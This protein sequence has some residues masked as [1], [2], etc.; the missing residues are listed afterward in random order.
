MNRLLLAVLLSGSV[1]VA[2]AADAP[3]A[4]KPAKGEAKDEVRAER[5]AFRAALA[6]A[7]EAFKRDGGDPAEHRRRMR[8]LR[9]AHHDKIRA[10]RLKQRQE[11]VGPD[12]K[13]RPKSEKKK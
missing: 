6:D 10:M 12:G 1:A 9:K 4:E 5:E 11:R 2:R 7:E 8:D 13:P 3:A